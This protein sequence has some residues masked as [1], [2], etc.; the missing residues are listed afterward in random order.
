MTEPLLPG[1]T[2]G[3]LGGGQLGRMFAQAARRMGYRV[4]VLTTEGDSPAAQVA[5]RATV[6]AYDDREAVTAFAQGVAAVT[7][8]FE[9]V[10]AAMAEAASAVAPV[11]PSGR[12]LEV[13]QNRLLEKEAVAGLGL[14][15]G[16]FQPVVVEAD[17]ATAAA[18][19]P[20]GAILKTAESGYDGKGQRRLAD[21]SELEAA[22]SELGRV[23]CILE[24]L[25]PFVREI[26]VVGARGTDGEVALFAPFEN[27]HARQILDLTLWPAAITGE[28]EAAAHG[29]ARGV[30]EGLEV[31]GVLCVELFVLE[32]GSLL[33]NE[34]APRP[35]NSGHLTLEAA[36]SSQFEQQVR[37]VTGLPLGSPERRV[38][39]AAMANLLGDLWADGE[40]DWAAALEVP[41]VS[42]HLYGKA[43]ARP[44][45][46]MGHLTATGSTRD[47]AEQRVQAARAALQRVRAAHA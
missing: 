23:P 26:S 19:I 18:A 22:W 7:L 3:M 41:G 14:P 43:E 20:G 5:D 15:V 44:G 36:V 10:P 34:L 42:L 12:L 39:G 30:L 17:L 37:A 31:V 2:L 33:V 6:A 35:H 28:T 21:A 32:D 40:P 4:A 9:N 47:E 27:Q 16:R 13:A 45:R 29:V 46:K 1:T 38:G 11:R 8:E 25:V 24:E